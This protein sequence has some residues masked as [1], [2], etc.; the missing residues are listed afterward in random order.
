MVS[1]KY[2]KNITKISFCL[3][4]LIFLIMIF[5]YLNDHMRI[6]ST[7]AK[8]LNTA[9]TTFPPQYLQIPD[10]AL[11]VLVEPMQWQIVSENG[12]LTTAWILPLDAAGWHTNS[13]HAGVSGNVVL[14]GHHLRGEQIFN[15]FSL[16]WAEVGQKITLT[17]KMGQPFIYEIIEVTEPILSHRGTKAD[18]ER[19][20][21]YIAPTEHAQLTLVTGWPSFSTT[22]RIF[23]IAKLVQKINV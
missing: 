12:N 18:Q 21:S 10:I 2:H 5:D 14:S 16:G 11:D 13:A 4:I 15:V 20:L 17:D 6:D 1:R 7:F 22:H 19:S 3:I 9:T 8:S 23:V